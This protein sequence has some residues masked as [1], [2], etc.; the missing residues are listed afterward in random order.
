ML[1]VIEILHG[2]IPRS[3]NN[4]SSVCVYKIMCIYIYTSIYLHTHVCMGSCRS[5]TIYRRFYGQSPGIRCNAEEG[6]V[7]MLFG[8]LLLAQACF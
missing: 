4:G 5:S 2:L 3:E 8:R 6:E 7:K 1:L